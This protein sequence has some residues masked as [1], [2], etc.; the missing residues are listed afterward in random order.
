MWGRNVGFQVKGGKAAQVPL[1]KAE[2]AVL[3][4]VISLFLPTP[5]EGENG[6]FKEEREVA[7]THF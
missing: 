2:K 3:P 4:Q 6:A 1:C 5:P 7:R